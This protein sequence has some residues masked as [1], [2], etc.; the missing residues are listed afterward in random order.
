MTPFPGKNVIRT[1]FD[2]L[3][4]CSHK[5]IGSPCERDGPFRVPSER[6]AGNPQHRCLFLNSSRVCHH[7]TRFGH[8]ADE[9]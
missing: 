2:F 4:V 8:E 1:S 3:S 7:K 5:M 6:Q 9:G